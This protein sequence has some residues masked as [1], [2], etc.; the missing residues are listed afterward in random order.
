M[1]Q[2]Q[3]P[4]QLNYS[5]QFNLHFQCT[6]WPSGYFV[7]HADYCSKHYPT[8]LSKL[9]HLLDLYK[10]FHQNV[11]LNWHG[12]KLKIFHQNDY[13]RLVFG[14]KERIWFFGGGGDKVKQMCVCAWEP[15]M[16]RIRDHFC[17]YRIYYDHKIKEWV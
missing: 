11:Y 17:T 12:F 10:N 8:L 7:G 15:S 3:V 6:S 13:S 9:V 16:K 4:A 1:C 14:T 2:I 5:L